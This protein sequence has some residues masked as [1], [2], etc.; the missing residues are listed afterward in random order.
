MTI[1]F[2]YPD[3]NITGIVELMQY[4]NELVEGTFGVAFLII[5]GF[6]S[7]ISTKRYG[8]E[9]SF[10]YS[11]FITMISAILLRFLDMVN[12]YILLLVI[13][14]FI[15]SVIGLMRKRNVENFGV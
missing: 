5:I 6:I 11:T 3:N 15:I 8:T 12:D 4:A 7:F 1:P 2:R 13:A 14:L 10:G 9:E